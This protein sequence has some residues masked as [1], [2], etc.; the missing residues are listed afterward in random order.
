MNPL[1]FLIII[2]ILYGLI[3]GFF[4]GLVGEL[5]AIIAIVCAVIGS[6]LF[7]PQVATLLLKYLDLSISAA[8]TIAYIVLFLAIAMMLNIIG[9]LFRK[10]LHAISLEGFNRLLGAVFGTMKWA[11]IM[12]VIINGIA[13]LDGHFHFIKPE[14]KQTSIVY[15]P[16]K[17]LASVAWNEVQNL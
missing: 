2:P 5:T 3:R 7:A 9:N 1:D 8:Q 11:L 14:F 12:S 13:L 10:L 16:I 6:K 17:R 15:E 4:R